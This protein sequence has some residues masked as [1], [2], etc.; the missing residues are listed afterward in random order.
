MQRAFIFRCS[1][2]LC[3]L[4]CGLCLLSD[5]PSQSPTWTH[6]ALAGLRPLLQGGRPTPRPGRGSLGSLERKAGER[7]G[8]DVVL[9]LKFFKNV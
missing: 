3:A 5:A 2:A 8:G 6:W 4:V 7:R 9:V 1:W